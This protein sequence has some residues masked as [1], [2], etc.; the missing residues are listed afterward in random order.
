MRGAV[1]TLGSFGLGAAMMYLFDPRSGRRRRA[2][3]S[4][5][6]THTVKVEHDLIGKARRDLEHR[7][8][9]IV[10][11]VRGASAS[12][13]SDPVIAE[14]VRAAIGHLVSHPR[15]LE[16]AVQDGVVT[17]RGPILEDEAASLLFHVER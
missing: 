8:Q 5:Q 10:Q 13:L 14:R 2:A 1:R 7:A 16:V 17:L 9:G 4:N 12:D 6:V 15:A 11:Q 3:I